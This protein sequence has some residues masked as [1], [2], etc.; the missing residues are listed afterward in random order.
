[1]LQAVSV[2]SRIISR[3]SVIIRSSSIGRIK[4]K[5]VPTNRATVNTTGNKMRTGMTCDLNF[6]ALFN[7]TI[8]EIENGE[9]KF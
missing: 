6:N 1:M 5:M 2:N 7:K 8:P 9:L 3:L 4:R